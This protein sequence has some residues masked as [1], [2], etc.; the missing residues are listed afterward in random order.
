ML[1]NEIWDQYKGYWTP[2]NDNSSPFLG[3]LRK[4]RLTLKQI[5]ELRILCDMRKADRQQK[6]KKLHRQYGSVPPKSNYTR[7]KS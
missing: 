3:D 7:K 1:L 6:L 4:T 5:R 2:N